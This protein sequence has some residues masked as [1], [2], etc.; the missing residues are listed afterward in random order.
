MPVPVLAESLERRALP[1][2]DLI[3]AAERR[4]RFL[5]AF[6]RHELTD[7]G[8]AMASSVAGA[9]WLFG[10]QTRGLTRRGQPTG[11]TRADR[12]SRPGLGVHECECPFH[13]EL[14]VDGVDCDPAHLFADGLGEFTFDA[15]VHVDALVEAAASETCLETGG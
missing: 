7:V 3:D 6:D 11:R 8:A 15:L 1:A 14:G 5:V 12:Q 13:T 2:I 9:Q 4:F 10:R